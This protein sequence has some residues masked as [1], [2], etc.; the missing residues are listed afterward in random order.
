MGVVM[1]QS[2]FAQKPA[3]SKFSLETELNLAG[4]TITAPGIKLRYF[5]SETMAIRFGF[6]YGSSKDSYN[7]SD[8]GSTGTWTE[9]GSGMAISPGIEFHM[10]GTDRLSPYAG[11]GISIGMGSNSTE[12]S[13]AV[14]AWTYMDGISSSSEM[15]W[16]SFGWGLIAGADY[17]FADSFYAGVEL[18]LGGNTV[19]YKEGDT[20]STV[21][22]TTTTTTS[23][24]SKAASMGVEATGGIRLG[25]R[26]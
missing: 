14:D 25:W 3:D 22:G 24:E 20:S 5:M 19:T 2:T 21:A 7:P 6:D 15:P 8:S 11:F 4:T 18:S 17:Y 26:F 10:A 16:S 12:G 1:T 13:N 23:D 9:S